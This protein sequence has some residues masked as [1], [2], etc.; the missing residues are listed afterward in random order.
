MLWYLNL[1]ANAG[2]V[3]TEYADE[4]T[5]SMVEREDGGGQ[6]T[7]VTLRPRVKYSAGVDREL[8][9]KIHEQAHEL[10]FIANSVNFPVSCVAS[11]EGGGI[12]QWHCK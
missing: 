1:C 5:G 10:C 3:V 8:A 12:T 4:A 7:E 6:F 2:I 11:I 9:M